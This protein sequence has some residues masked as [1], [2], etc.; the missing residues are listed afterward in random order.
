MKK[1][2][3]I[4][5]MVLILIPYSE[6][7]KSLYAKGLTQVKTDKTE[8]K[9]TIKDQK[10]LFVT[11]YNQG[12]A[13]IGDQ[14]SLALP[15]GENH[16]EFR[17][18]SAK[19]I[20]ETAILKAQK[21]KVLEQN[22]EFDLLTPQSLLNKF[23]GKNVKIVKTNPAT[24]EEKV[25]DAKILS[26][27]NGIVLKLDNG[28]ETGIPGRIIFPYIPKNLKTS[29]TL[30]M[31]VKS[32][33]KRIQNLELSYLTHGLT[34][35]SDYV[36]ELNISDNALD[37]TGWV[38]LT[39][40]SGI[41]YNNAQLKL[42]A[43]DINIAPE[44]QKMYMKTLTMAASPTA[45]RAFSREQLFEYHLY[46]LNRKTDI[47]DNQTKQVV[48]LHSENIPCKKEFI[49]T[50]TNN[51]W[52]YRRDNFRSHPKI[53]VYLKFKNSK[54]NHL[55]IPL[56]KGVIR[57]YKKDSKGNIQFA[58][59]DRIDHTPE[60]AVIRLKLG[61]AFDITAEKRQTEFIKLNSKGWN[62]YKYQ[63]GYEIKIMNSRDKSASVKVVEPVQGQWKITDENFPHF[64]KDAGHAVWNIFVP[65]KGITT[66][67]YT[68]RIK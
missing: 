48:L 57:V 15:N 33:T 18:I 7:G 56:P 40:T 38:T 63:S 27:V 50:G 41:S 52:Y 22:F 11:I 55:G 23:K 16:L 64:R 42:V 43:G 17:D 53:A 68:I 65:A 5:V 44:R 9:T 46:S 28:M 29:P 39:N 30:T 2:I 3:N 34:W 13:L 26:T 36:A 24:G 62:T 51:S 4:L 66:L 25:L 54:K 67:K 58:G 59:E 1:I 31:L 61:N 14:R 12:I 10:S 19:I 21:L 60:N 49:L 20:P 32:K 35:K 8:I 37:L 47:K 6:Y 45:D